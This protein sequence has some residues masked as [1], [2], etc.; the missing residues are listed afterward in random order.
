MEPRSVTRY[1]AVAQAL[2][3]ITAL[4]V[5]L[6]FLYGP[7]GSEQHV[8]APARDFDRQLHETLGLSVLAL[9]ALRVLWR[10]FDAHPAPPTVARWM[11]LAA[12]AVQGGLYVLLFAVPVTA[13]MG[14]WLEGHPLTLLAG[15]KI[16]PVL[17]MA[18]AAGAIF[19][20]IH[21]WL[22]DTILWLAGF[23]ALAGLYHHFILRDQ[24]L[25]AMLPRLRRARHPP[26]S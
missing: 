14:A 8:Y 18:H 23:H 20:R 3:W 21:P 12:M 6:A 22:G 5:L 13:I 1:G 19:A 10:L 4:L 16:P 9:V 7:G 2:H 11:A 25:L 15:V 24:T 17:G 26:G